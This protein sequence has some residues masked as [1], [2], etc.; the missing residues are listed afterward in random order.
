MKVE[1]EI[2][3]DAP[4]AVVFSRL[5]DAFFF[6]SCIDGVSDLVAIDNTH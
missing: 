2:S 1:G 3:V 6:A 4:R 5:S